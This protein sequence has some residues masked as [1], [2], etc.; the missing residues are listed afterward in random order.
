[1]HIFVAVGFF[2]GIKITGLKLLHICKL[3]DNYY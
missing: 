2:S 3:F 1:M